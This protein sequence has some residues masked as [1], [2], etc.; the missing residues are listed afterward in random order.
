MT[1]KKDT[2][3]PQQKSI[4]GILKPLYHVQIIISKPSVMRQLAL[5]GDINIAVNGPLW[6]EVA[7]PDHPFVAMLISHFIGTCLITRHTVV[8]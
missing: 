4:F 8:M 5:K 6:V 3:K 7:N 2:S 1:Q